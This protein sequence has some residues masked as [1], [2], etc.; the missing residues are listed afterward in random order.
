MALMHVL[1]RPPKPTRAGWDT[2]T[3]KPHYPDG[4]RRP[5]R[6]ANNMRFAGRAVNLRTA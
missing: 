6:G 1:G 2:P 3:L 5:Q 4:Y